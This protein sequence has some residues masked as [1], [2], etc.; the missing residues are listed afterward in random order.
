M[1]AI[2]CYWHL[3][4]RR[5]NFGGELGGPHGAKHASFLFFI[6]TYAFYMLLSG[7]RA[8]KPRDLDSVW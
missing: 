5:D 4:Y 1:G 6:S 7:W 2:A 8:S 3:G